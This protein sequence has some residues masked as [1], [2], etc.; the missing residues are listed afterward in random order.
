MSTGFEKI[1]SDSNLQDHWIRRLIAFII[2]SIIAWI[3]TTI[4]VGV[5]FLPLIVLAAITDLPWFVF[6]PFTFPFFAGI[7]SV[8]YFALLEFW[9]GWTFGKRIMSLRTIETN[10]QKPSFDR[11]LIRNIS[12]IYWIL[13]LIDVII[14]LATL[15]DPHQKIA[16]RFAGTTVTSKTVSPSASTPHPPPPPT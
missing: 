13:A 15:G 10:G 5:V 8:L 1:A 9:Y 7:L 14:G 6:N 2:D 11:A 3:A 4:I 12:K 16:D